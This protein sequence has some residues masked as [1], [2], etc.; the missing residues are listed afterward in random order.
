MRLQGTRVFALMASC[1]A[2]ALVARFCIAGLIPTAG[3]AEGRAPAN[4]AATG[5]PRHFH[6][7]VMAPLSKKILVDPD[8]RT[9]LDLNFQR[10][11]DL[12]D[13]AKYTLHTD[14]ECEKL[15]VTLGYP[16]LKQA[17]V[18][19]PHGAYKSDICRVAVLYDNGGYYSDDDVLAEQ[20]LVAVVE[21]K[22]AKGA[23]F[24]SQWE[25]ADGGV[26][27]TFIAAA[28][29][30]EVMRR[31]LE[32]MDGLYNGTFKRTHTH[33][34][35]GTLRDAVA[36][37]LAAHPGRSEEVFMMKEIELS[38]KHWSNPFWVAR[39]CRLV[40]A[41]PDPDGFG[42]LFRSHGEGSRSCPDLLSIRGWA[43]AAREEWKGRKH[44]W[45]PVVI[46]VFCG[47]GWALHHWVLRFAE[48][49]QETAKYAR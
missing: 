49:K 11:S 2:L 42:V 8:A 34:G 21:A 48:T 47:I 31:A 17:M 12:N 33:I 29:R 39:N 16:K 30:H 7:I 45:A 1:Q 20:S 22:Y 35:P 32:R 15:L 3:G 23:R 10:L 13:G 6:F 4:T 36:G 9:E 43:K 38:R 28:P 19:E 27:N 5:I 40:V 24:V 18:N 25:E 14:D 26:F 44:V 41:D 37:F 46:G